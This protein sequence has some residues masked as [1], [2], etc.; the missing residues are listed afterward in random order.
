[1]IGL[2][3]GIFLLISGIGN[4]N[5]ISQIDKYIMENISQTNDLIKDGVNKGELS[6]SIIR[7]SIGSYLSKARN[8]L[9]NTSD[10]TS[11]IQYNNCNDKLYNTFIQQYITYYIYGASGF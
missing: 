3:I 10:L 8:I 7:E 1:M 4:C 2:Y 9:R 6:N 5:L 11:R